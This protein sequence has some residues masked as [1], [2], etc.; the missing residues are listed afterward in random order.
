M[1]YY[2]KTI[3]EIGTNMYPNTAE[4]IQI[5]LYSTRHVKMDN[6]SRVSLEANFARNASCGASRVSLWNQIPLTELKNVPNKNFAKQKCLSREFR[7]TH[8]RYSLFLSSFTCRVLYDRKG[9]KY[10]G[11]VLSKRP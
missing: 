9:S 10:N 1:Y 6:A 11:S 5:H 8:E 4:W 7:G 2:T 3:T